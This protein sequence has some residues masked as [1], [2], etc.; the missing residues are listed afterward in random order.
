[1]PIGYGNHPGTHGPTYKSLSDR[2]QD[3]PMSKDVED[4]RG[5]HW[6]ITLKLNRASEK[7]A[8]PI[9]KKINRGLDKLGYPK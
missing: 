1:M 3:A 2:A 8:T 9:V 6:G 7:Y 4:R 5:E